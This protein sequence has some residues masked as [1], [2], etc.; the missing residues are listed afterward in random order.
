MNIALDFEGWVGIITGTGKR[1]SKKHEGGKAQGLSK[2][3]ENLS[4][5][6]LSFFSITS[7]GDL[8]SFHELTARSA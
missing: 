1:M 6:L 8:M 7:H 5:V 3:R 4:Q 2:G